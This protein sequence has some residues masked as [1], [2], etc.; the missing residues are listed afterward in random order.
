MP[1]NASSDKTTT[2]IADR[3][4]VGDYYTDGVDVW[5]I[6][7]NYAL[8]AVDLRNIKTGDP[9]FMGDDAFRRKLWLVKK[10]A[11]DA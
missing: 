1:S 9:R 10:A 3:R 4:E 7:K 8:G 11:S 6:T 2:P 5:E